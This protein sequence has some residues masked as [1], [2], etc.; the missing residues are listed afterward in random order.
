M[1]IYSPLFSVLG[2][3]LV[4]AYF[5]FGKGLEFGQ[6][7]VIAS[8]LCLAGF[9]LTGALSSREL[10]F[11][12]DESSKKAKEAAIV[13]IMKEKNL[14]R[15]TDPEPKVPTKP[16]EE[17]YAALPEILGASGIYGIVIG[18]GIGDA[19]SKYIERT[20]SSV[21]NYFANNTSINQTLGLFTNSTNYPLSI[22]PI[23][24]LNPAE[25][26][27]LAGFLFT[28][29]PFIHGTILMFSKKWYLDTSGKSHYLLALVF[30]TV[31]FVLTILF[32]FIALN[33]SDTAFFIFSLWL[34]MGFNSVWLVIHGKLTKAV[35]KKQYLVRREW[36]FLNLNT[37]A[38]LSVFLFSS[39]NLLSINHFVGNDSLLNF[40]ILMV[41][42]SR[43][44]TDYV[45]SW[46]QFYETTI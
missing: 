25:T 38:F 6:V 10:K 4:L 9:F 18:L 37:F 1:K 44:L 29:I 32:Y 11:V 2:I 13:S 27:R 17:K 16:E 20:T 5:V 8:V 35:L 42:F 3:L 26:F 19:L 34:V 31:V 45:S 39:P 36:I 23:L 40:I 28:I 21:V 43:I 12:R 33:I 30:F 22:M 24:Q 41:L 7:C 46:E 15:G 14:T